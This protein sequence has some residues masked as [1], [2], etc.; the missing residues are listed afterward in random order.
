MQNTT[1]SKR[2]ITYIERQNEKK[3][4]TIR[5]VENIEID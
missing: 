5:K 4:P 2:K 1:K 3:K